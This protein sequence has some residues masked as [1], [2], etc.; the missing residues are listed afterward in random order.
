[1]SEQDSNQ[2]PPQGKPAHD[3]MRRRFAEGKAKM[4]RKLL[5]IGYNMRYEVPETAEER[6]M[7]PWE[8][9][10]AHVDRWLMSSKSAVKKPMDKMTHKELSH[11]ITQFEQVY[12]DYLSHL[13]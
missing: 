12:K 3:M 9:C 1:V 6:A 2:Q 8:V 5:A 7:K 4:I 11:A 13:K 10:K